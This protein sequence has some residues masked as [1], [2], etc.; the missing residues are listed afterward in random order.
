MINAS[1]FSETE[2]KG[3]SRK[4]EDEK[5]DLW[6]LWNKVYDKD[7]KGGKKQEMKDES[8]HSKS[9]Y[10]YKVQ[11]PFPFFPDP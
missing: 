10:A 2:Q 7:G 1:D 5:E 11:Y 4:D 9:D 8:N 3:S 6:K